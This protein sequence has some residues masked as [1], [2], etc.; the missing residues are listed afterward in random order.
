[1][2]FADK[3]VYKQFAAGSVVDFGMELYSIELSFDVLN[4]T[5]RGVDGF[6][7][8]IKSIRHPGYMVSVAHPDRAFTLNE[9]SVEQCSGLAAGEQVGVTELTLAGRYNLPAEVTAHQLHPI[10]DAQ[11]RNAQFKELFGYRRRPRLVDRHGSAGKD[12]PRRSK[13]TDRFQRH[14]K[15]VQFA[16]DMALAYPS[17]NHLG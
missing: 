3:S 11:N 10:R 9:E 13:G 7:Y 17:R 2:D 4:G 15:G 1:A 5:D 16:I 6:R 8:N 14:V 12:N